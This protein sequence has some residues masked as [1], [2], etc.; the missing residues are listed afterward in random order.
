LA[1]ITQTNRYKAAIEGAGITDWEPFLWTSDVAQFDFDAR[2]TDED[3]EA[4]R[5]FSAVAYAKNVTAFSGAV[6]AA[7]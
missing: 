5:K 3:P 4:F 7:A 6:G 1:L 2:W